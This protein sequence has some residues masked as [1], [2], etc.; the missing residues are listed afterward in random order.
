MYVPLL[1]LALA[2]WNTND[3]SADLSIFLPPIATSILHPPLF[4]EIF[5]NLLAARY[6]PSHFCC[7]YFKLDI[8]AFWRK[9]SQWKRHQHTCAMD[10]K[11]VSYAYYLLITFAR[12]CANMV[13]NTSRPFSL[14]AQ[15]VRLRKTFSN[16]DQRVF[17][18]G[19]ISVFQFWRV[20]RPRTCPETSRGCSMHG[21]RK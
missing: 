20:L 13:V 18:S 16:S 2:P 9:R 3:E 14:Q 15:Q 1:S 6:P 7:K 5:P 8:L 17:L 12:D 4:W 21:Y 10:T 11:I 19:G